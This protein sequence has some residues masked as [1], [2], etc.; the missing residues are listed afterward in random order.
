MPTWPGGKTVRR[1]HRPDP[2]DRAG[3]TRAAAG[4]LARSM[5]AQRA[6]PVY[7]TL[8]SFASPT[9]VA[10]DERPHSRRDEVHVH[11]F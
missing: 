5:G 11:L 9:A 3:T 8:I 1:A 4:S 6:N 10:R 7:A 2:V